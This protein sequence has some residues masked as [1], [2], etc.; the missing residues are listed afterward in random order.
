[1]EIALTRVPQELEVITEDER[2]LLK[3]IVSELHDET[4]PEP[5]ESPI[6]RIRRQLGAFRTK[7][8]VGLIYDI[9]VTPKAR[10][11]RSWNRQTKLPLVLTD[12]ESMELCR[13]II[14]VPSN[15]TIVSQ[16]LTDLGE[17][18]CNSFIEYCK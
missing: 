10:E 16:L 1:M 17:Y 6:E 8:L 9:L 7:E 13:L 14:Y 18:L 2:K 5:F 12:M 4:P 15:S 3:Q 11:R